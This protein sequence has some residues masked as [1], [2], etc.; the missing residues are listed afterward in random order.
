MS[1]ENQNELAELRKAID[2]V[3]EESAAILTLLKKLLDDLNRPK[4]SL[5]LDSSTFTGGQTPM[6][7]PL[8]IHPPK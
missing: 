8:L 7:P 5:D 4:L 1:E 3:H 2:V 6:Y